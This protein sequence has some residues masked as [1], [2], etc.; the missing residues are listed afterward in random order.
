MRR[1][2]NFTIRRDPDHAASLVLGAWIADLQLRSLLRFAPP[3]LAV[4]RHVAEAVAMFMARY[5]VE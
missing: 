5:V 3:R 2:I 4:D 1:P